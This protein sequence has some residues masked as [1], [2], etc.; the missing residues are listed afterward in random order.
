MYLF[1]YDIGSSS[2]KASLVSADTGKCVSTAFFPRP[3]PRL[4][5]RTG[6]AEQHPSEWWKHLRREATEAIMAESKVDPATYPPSAF[7]IR[8][9]GWYASTAHA[10]SYVRPSYGVTPRSALRRKGIRRT[11]PDLCLGPSAQ[12]S[13]QLHRH[14]ARVGQGE[15][16]PEAV[17]PH[18]ENPLL[19][20][21]TSP[22]VLTGRGLHRERPLGDDAL[23]LRGGCSRCLPDGLPRIFPLTYCPKS[24][25]HSPSRGTVTAEVAPNLASRVSPSYR[26]GDQPNN[27]LSL[28][29][30]STPVR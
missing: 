11:W 6:W 17:R 5:R 25:P 22:C 21:T 14:Q 15:N 27:A 9:T 1:G 13:R 18:M 30:Y 2:V 20:V 7:P 28:N 10:M 4:S 16:E 19:Q 8:C 3:R 23:G 12:L 24:C 26:A 29:V